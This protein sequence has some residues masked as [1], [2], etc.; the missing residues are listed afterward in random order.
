MGSKA[1]LRTSIDRLKDV[2]SVSLDG[3][4]EK[5]CMGEFRAKKRS[6]Q[7]SAFMGL[8]LMKP[9]AQASFP[10]SR[11]TFGETAFV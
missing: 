5:D 8:T 10:V 4:E 9:N 7:I 3:C 6:E 1:G 2:E 11:N